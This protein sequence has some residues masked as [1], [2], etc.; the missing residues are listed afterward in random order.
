MWRIVQLE[1]IDKKEY[2]NAHIK[3]EKVK[4]A[5]YIYPNLLKRSFT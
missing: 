4:A 3:V 1:T 2:V 5:G